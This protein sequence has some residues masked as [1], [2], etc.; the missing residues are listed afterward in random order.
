[1]ENEFSTLDIVKALKI[2]R[3][4][5]RDW[6]NRSFID[7]SVPADGQGTKAIF[8]LQDVYGVALFQALINS[9]FN[10]ETSSRFVKFFMEKEKEKEEVK[11]KDRAKYDRIKMHDTDYLVLRVPEDRKEL[12]RAIVLWDTANESYSPRIDLKSG[13]PETEASKAFRAS[14]KSAEFFTE[15]ERKGIPY[16]LDITTKWSIIHV[17]NYKAIREKV[18]EALKEL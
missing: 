2:P 10:R 9:G 16:E 14:P 15:L 11:E 4:R 12:I 5:L 7:P 3:E 13:L 17:V 6:M 8:S 18:D 1:M